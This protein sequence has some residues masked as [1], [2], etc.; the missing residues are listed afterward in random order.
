MNPVQL[1]TF[2]NILVIISAD[3]SSVA[4]KVIHADYGAP[5]ATRINN[6]IEYIVEYHGNNV[7]IH[8]KILFKI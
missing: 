5:F 8:C 3:Q 6:T 1:I 2:I 7:S 4:R